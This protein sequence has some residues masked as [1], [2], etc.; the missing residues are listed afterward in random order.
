MKFEFSNNTI[1]T[2]QGIGSLWFGVNGVG[3]LVAYAPATWWAFNMLFIIIGLA[4]WGVIRG[5]I[6][7]EIVD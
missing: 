3:L 4:I 6:R 2:A 1:A 5:A 7:Y